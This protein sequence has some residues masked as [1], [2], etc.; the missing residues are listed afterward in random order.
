[1][2]KLLLLVG[3][4]VALSACTS[5]QERLSAAIAQ[6][7][8]GDQMGDPD[9]LKELAELKAQYGMAYYD[10]AAAPYLYAAGLHFFQEKKYERSIEILY[11]YLERDDSSELFR[12]A[13]I[14]LASA[15]NEQGEF[16]KADEVVSE[17]LDQHLPT[18]GQWQMI[19]TLYQAHLD[20]ASLD[21]HDR[22]AMAYTATGSFQ[23]ALRVLELAI[24]KFPDH[25][26]RSDIVYRAGF[27]GW[28]YLQDEAIA[29]K[30]YTLF[31]ED[32]PNDVR[33]AQVRNIL[34][35]GYLSMSNEQ[36]LEIIKGKE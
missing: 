23:E 32:Y 3:L 28:E 21:Q 10:S 29:T 8:Q 33:A 12:N 5:K 17:V 19:I 1:M 30:Y 16:T 22:L 31:L 35:Q 4:A 6:L 2:K 24:S 34:D 11:E 26:K 14:T 27:V 7:E 25:E 36:I 20:E 15:L 13:G 9:M 18:Y